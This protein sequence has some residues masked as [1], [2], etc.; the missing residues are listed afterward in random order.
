MG[1]LDFV[2]GT[3]VHINSG[4]AALVAFPC[5]TVAAMPAGDVTFARDTVANREPLD[6]APNF[7]DHTDELVAQHA[8]ESHV[9]LQEFEVGVAD[10]RQA[11]GDASHPRGALGFVAV[12]F[13]RRGILGRSMGHGVDGLQVVGRVALSPR[14]SVCLLRVGTGRAVLVGM[15]GD[16]M[17]PLASIDEPAELAELLS[18]VDTG[19]Q[20]AERATE[21]ARVETRDSHGQGGLFDLVA[22]WRKGFP[23]V[24]VG[25]KR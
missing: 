14:H 9:A 24:G 13:W 7:S 3:V 21:S 23:F 10:A 4:V 15:C 22:S 5:A 18:S 6:V 20:T 1:A 8:L 16:Q 19:R 17:S 11:D 2:G 25:D 12:W